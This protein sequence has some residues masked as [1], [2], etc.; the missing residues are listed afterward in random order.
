MGGG[1]RGGGGIGV[2]ACKGK[3]SCGEYIIVGPGSSGI[4]NGRSGG[5][6]ISSKVIT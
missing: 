6:E 5:L 4:G 1:S 2:G 3:G